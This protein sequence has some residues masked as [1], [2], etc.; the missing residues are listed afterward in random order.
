MLNRLEYVELITLQKGLW[1]LRATRN[2]AY[3]FRDNYLI[4]SIIYIFLNFVFAM[5]LL[6]CP[7]RADPN[8][9]VC[10]GMGR[11]AL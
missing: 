8:E 4:T 10:L 2:H 7:S 3:I 6:S 9:I 5:M 11:A 1:G